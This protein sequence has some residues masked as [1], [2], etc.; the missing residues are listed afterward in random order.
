MLQKQALFRVFPR[1]THNYV[2]VCSP[3][4]QV[5]CWDGGVGGGGGAVAFDTR[6]SVT[7]PHSA[8]LLPCA[9]FKV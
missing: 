7:C 4:I 5:L 3:G 6:A 9:K 1:W 2:Y 8:R